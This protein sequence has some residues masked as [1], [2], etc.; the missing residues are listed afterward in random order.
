MGTVTLANGKTYA[1]YGTLDD[2]D[3]YLAGSPYALDWDAA[4]NDASDDERGERALITASRLLDSLSWQGTSTLPV[5]PRI[6]PGTV[7]QPLAWPRTGV[8]INGVEVASN[9]IPF[10]VEY[11]A[12][13]L[14]AVII[15]DQSVVIPTG[16]S[17]V[18]RVQADTAQ[19]EFFGPQS[20]TATELSAMI[21]FLLGPYLAG[22]SDLG[23]DAG[24]AVGNDGVFAFG[25][26]SGYPVSGG[27]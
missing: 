17:N 7:T 14:A 12:Y 11:A 21:N 4:R 5:D 19:I 9:V 15:E 27:L 10:A 6:I 24:E 25:D 23:G 16:A 3:A 18:K 8:V 2:A 22:G 26:E 1:V 20:A 13:T